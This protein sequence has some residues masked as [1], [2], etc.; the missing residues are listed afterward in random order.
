MVEDTTA[1]ESFWA[2]VTQ[3]RR[4]AAC[5]IDKET[6]RRLHKLTDDIEFGAIE[7]LRKNEAENRK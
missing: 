1:T 3:F 5:A 4:V 2:R 7:I 6:S